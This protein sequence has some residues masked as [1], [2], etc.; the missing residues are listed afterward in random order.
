MGSLEELA[1]VVK[2]VDTQGL[3]PCGATHVGSSPTDGTNVQ[4]HL[5]R[6]FKRVPIHA[7][8]LRLNWL[9]RVDDLR[10]LS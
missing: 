3:G 2:L 9:V 6:Q 8:K 5:C 10:C 4:N 1:V 7:R